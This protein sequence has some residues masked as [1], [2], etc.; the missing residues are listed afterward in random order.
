MHGLY[1]TKLIQARL[2][3]EGLY[4]K[5]VCSIAIKAFHTNLIP[6]SLMGQCHNAGW[7]LI[8]LS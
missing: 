3:M 6:I 8:N 7:H 2:K 4:T 1:K 5:P